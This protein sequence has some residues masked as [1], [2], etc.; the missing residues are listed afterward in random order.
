MDLI[1]QFW[2]TIKQFDTDVFLFLNNINTP[3]MDII[4]FWLS[5]KWIWLPLYFGIAFL[6]FY[7]LRRFD[8]RLV[9]VI[10]LIIAATDLTCSLFLKPTFK[11]PRPCHELALQSKIHQ[12]GNC[13]GSFGFAS[14]HAGNTFAIA[15]F[16]FLWFR[17]N[18]YFGFLF[19]WAFLV[20]YSRIYLGVHYPLDILVG[21]YIGVLF[22]QLGYFL[23]S[24]ELKI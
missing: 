11:R 17:K 14:S 22:A 9:I 3:F 7:K 23:C 21:A 5:H 13:G 20:S 16:V 6:L 2:K 4:M 19:I 10:A 12:V 8:L 18:K 24:K 15:T 1:L